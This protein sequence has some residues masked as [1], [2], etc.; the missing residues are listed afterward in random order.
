MG[1]CFRQTIAEVRGSDLLAVRPYLRHTHGFSSAL[2]PAIIS[3]LE[4]MVDHA[5][6]SDIRY[7]DNRIEGFAVPMKD[8][9]QGGTEA[10]CGAWK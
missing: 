6:R 7:E 3:R 10:A 9:H 5:G 8:L 4:E 2:P 1:K